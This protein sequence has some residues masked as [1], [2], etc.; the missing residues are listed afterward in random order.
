MRI[1]LIE[2]VLNRAH[3]LG[4]D[5]QIASL[6][7][8]DVLGE[9]RRLNVVRNSFSHESAKSEVQAK[10]IIEEA[11]PVFREVL[12]DLRELQSIDLIRI[13]SIQAGGTAEIERLN[14]HAQS[15]RSTT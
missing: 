6:L 3:D 15:R 8:I 12:L 5:L 7:P 14:G 1:G 11:Y 4:V 2:G 13:H 9:V 10:A